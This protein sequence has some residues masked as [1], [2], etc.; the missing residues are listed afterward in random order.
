[1]IRRITAGGDCRIEI[2]FSVTVG[3]FDGGINWQLTR[4]TF[5]KTEKHAR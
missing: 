1:M 4:T 3:D 5:G 2:R